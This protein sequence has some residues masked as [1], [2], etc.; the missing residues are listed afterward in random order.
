MWAPN[1]LWGRSWRK[2]KGKDKE[3]YWVVKLNTCGVVECIE[4]ERDRGS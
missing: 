4:K 2:D 3:S 1:P